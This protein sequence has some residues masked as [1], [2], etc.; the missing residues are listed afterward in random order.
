MHASLPAKV[1]RGKKQPGI[2]A[3]IRI[4]TELIQERIS[5]YIYYESESMEQVR[6]Q[7]DSERLKVM[8]MII[9]ALILALAAS[10]GFYMFISRSIT[11]PVADL[12]LKLLQAQIN[13]HFLY[14][15][16]DNIIWLAEDGRKD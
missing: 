1:G 12:E 5:E 10:V 3:D 16:L 8:N 13:P 11:E 14:N 7:M 6:T 15:T 9:L 2:D 4:L